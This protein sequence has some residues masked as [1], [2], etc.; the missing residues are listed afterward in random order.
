MDAAAVTGGVGYQQD[1]GPQS[2]NIFM[3]AELQRYLA[4]WEDRSRW[5]VWGRLGVRYGPAFVD[6]TAMLDAAIG[7][8]LSI[9]AGFWFGA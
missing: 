5:G 3:E 2:F 7:G 1:F 4:G 6:V 8:E 9:G